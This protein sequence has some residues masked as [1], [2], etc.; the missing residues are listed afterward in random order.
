MKS[1]LEGGAAQKVLLHI[2]YP[3]T[4]TT[5]L[6]Q[7]AFLPWHSAGWVDY[8]GV[9]QT[10]SHPFDFAGLSD[11]L[12]DAVYLADDDAALA[13][14][15]HCNQLL[16]SMSTRDKAGHPIVIS[17][18]HF[19]MGGYSTLW[20]DLAIWPHRSAQRLRSVLEGFD[21]RIV[22]VL[23]DHAELAQAYFLQH[24]ATPVHA[25][26]SRYA[27]MDKFIEGII[28]GVGCHAQMFQFS[29]VLD[30]YGDAFG[31]HRIHA[32]GFPD[33]C[34][35]M[36]AFIGDLGR[37][38]GI[39]HEVSQRTISRNNARHRTESGYR[40]AGLGLGAYLAAA[41]RRI[42]GLTSSLRQVPGTRTLYSLLERVRVSD[43][44]EVERLTPFQSQ[45][46]GEAFSEDRQMVCES[47]GIRL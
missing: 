40:S 47:W 4:A 21:V 8:L 32:Y 6:Q 15:K 1:E 29:S 3:K 30:A 44:V 34:R 2:G 38:T 37:L 26:E 19:T 45:A 41:S 9:F 25:N 46:I 11:S 33:V 13:Q 31:Y 39:T 43:G 42:P 22:V 35:D 18:E 27:S 7:Q 12:R 24:K 14:A 20:R 17:S 10:Q 28:G 23:R 5:T 16:H 36:N